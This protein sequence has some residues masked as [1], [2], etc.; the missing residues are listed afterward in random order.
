MAGTPG[1]PPFRRIAIVGVGLIGGSIGL[2]V[3]RFVRGCEV[4]GIDR[5]AVLRLARA[6]GA[7]DETSTSLAR[8]V[9]GADLVV[10]ALPVEAVRRT[11]WRLATL[12]PEESLL[13]DVS[14]TKETI[15]SEV[16]RL[17]LGARFVGG[18]PMAGSEHSG[19]AHADGFLFTGAS[20]L[21]CPSV[22]ATLSG[23][24]R[25]SRGVRVGPPV[26]RVSVLVKR[27][28]ARPVVLT[29]RAHDLIVA[30]LS[31]LPQLASVALT[32]A[33]GRGGAR[34]VLHLAGPALRQM[35][36][37]ADS[38]PALWDGILKSN[39]R[40]VTAALDDLVQELKKLKASLRTGPAAHFRRAARLRERLR[41]G[42]RGGPALG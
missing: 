11:L 5:P 1:G 41:A 13:T 2:A 28:G 3:R 38:P 12:L 18:H 19:I 34:S 20:W 42:G 9:A 30:R 27:L 6:R 17:G 10:L 8:G 39:R 4:V 35:S 15:D 26:Q 32:N 24:D 25:R 23:A 16:R 37:L 7:V 40:A 31:H 36:R 29:P 22:R 21:L 14:S 33:S